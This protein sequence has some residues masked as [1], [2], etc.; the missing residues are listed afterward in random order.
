MIDE[1]IKE[2]RRQLN[3]TQADLARILGISR[4]SV[5]AWEQGLTNPSIKYLIKLAKTFK[6]STDYLLGLEETSTLDISDLEVKDAEMVYSMVNHLRN[7][8]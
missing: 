6:T 5:N 7:K 4:S 3:L 8:K 1:R 2:L